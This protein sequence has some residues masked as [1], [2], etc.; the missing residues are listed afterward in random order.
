MKLNEQT[1]TYSNALQD[2]DRSRHCYVRIVYIQRG[3]YRELVRNRYGL[4]FA[5]TPLW[6]LLNMKVGMARGGARSCS[7]RFEGNVRGNFRS[8]D[9]GMDQKNS[10]PWVR[11]LWSDRSFMPVNIEKSSFVQ[12]KHAECASG[13]Y[14]LQRSKAKMNNA[15][16]TAVYRKFRSFI[17]CQNQDDSIHLRCSSEGVF[18]LQKQDQGRSGLEGKPMILI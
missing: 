3:K 5:L 7:L 8:R 2:Q 18:Y 17:L 13:C 4:I 15:V 9:F 1:V 11:I 16:V 10:T 14:V 6:P 12:Q